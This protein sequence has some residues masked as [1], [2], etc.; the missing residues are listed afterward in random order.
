[1]EVGLDAEKVKQLDA[2]VER[3]YEAGKYAEAICHCR[4]KPGV[5]GGKSGAGT[6][7]YRHQPQQPGGALQ[8]PRAS[9][10]R[11][12]RSTSALWRS[13]KKLWGRSTPIPPPAST[14][15]RALHDQGLYAK[16][17][18]LYQRALAIDE[19]ALGPEHPD[20]ATSLNN[21]AVLYDAQGHYA[22]AEPL[23][24]R[25]LAI[26]EKALG[27][28][29]PDTATSLNNLAEL[30]STRASTPRPSR[31]TS[32]LWR[33]VKKP[34]G[35][36]T[37]IPPPA[38]TTWR[39]STTQGHYA[40]AEPLYQRALAIR[41]KTLGPEHPDTANSLNNLAALYT[42]RATT[43]RPSRSTSALWRS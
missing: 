8:T 23:Y 5:E 3:L 28:E 32:A 9:T 21:L 33:S 37:L 1:M 27:P 15:W 13:A 24:Q 18:P 38:S 12:S 14:T 29:H 11:P 16:A 36:S 41:E 10:P 34:W 4:A 25:A 26:R 40:K 22:K 42:P 6:P 7:R 39:R 31:S 2:E 43:P 19:K 20:T 35:R 30:Y 17:E